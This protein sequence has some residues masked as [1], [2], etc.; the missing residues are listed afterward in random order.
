MAVATRKRV[1]AL[2]L[3]GLATAAVLHGTYNGMMR[4]QNTVPAIVV[5]GSFVLFYAYLT[6]LRLTVGSAAATA[7]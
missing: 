5:F 3:V 4:I 2:F 1:A 6:R 7:T